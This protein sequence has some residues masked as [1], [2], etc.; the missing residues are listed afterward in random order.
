MDEYKHNIINEELKTLKDIELVEHVRFSFP[1]AIM[2]SDLRQLATKWIKSFDYTNALNKAAAE[3][4][5]P[6]KMVFA[7]NF[8]KGV[9]MN[10]FNT[11]EEELK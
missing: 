9:L 3:G 10:L 4:E 2:V 7:F 1:K 6:T 8:T 5:E 11:T